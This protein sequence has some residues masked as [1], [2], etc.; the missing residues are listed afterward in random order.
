MRSLLDDAEAHFYPSWIAEEE[1]A[2]LFEGLLREI[3]FSQ[4]AIQL[5]GRLRERNLTEEPLE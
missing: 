3:P 4:S 2:L 5:F 1:A